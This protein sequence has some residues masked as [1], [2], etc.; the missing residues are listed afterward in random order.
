MGETRS[1]MRGVA[2]ATATGVGCAVAYPDVSIAP[3]A[4]LAYAP[5]MLW[6]TVDRPTPGRAFWVGLLA[7]TILYSVGHN[8]LTFTLQNMSGT[9]APLAWLVLLI[10]AAAMGLHQACW[11]AACV[12][13]QDAFAPDKP[14]GLRWALTVAT[15]L[16][17]MEYVI[18]HQFPWFLGNALYTLPLLMQAADLAGIW[19]IS[20]L[21]ALTSA[22]LVIAA[23]G[24][25]M[26]DRARAVV[27]VVVMLC[28][29][30]GYGQWRIEQ[31]SAVA[32]DRTVTAALIQPNPSLAEKMSGKAAR[33]LPMLDRAEKLTRD[34]LDDPHHG[35][36]IDVVIWPEGSLPFFYVHNEIAPLA[37]HT[38]RPRAPKVVKHT[39]ARAHQFAAQLGKPLLLGSLRKTDAQWHQRTRNSAIL[40][41]GA[42]PRAI[43][44]KRK[45]VPFGEHIPASSLLPS[46]AT[47]I[48]GASN[49]A[50][51]QNSSLMN[52]AGTT[53]AV[54]ICYEA[55]FAGFMLAHNATAEV[56]VNLT[57]DIWFGPQ[58]AP[59]QHLMVQYPRAIELRRPLLRATATG[60]SAH[61][62]AAGRVRS[63]TGTGKT[64]TLLEKVEVRSID[65]VFR[66]LGLW[67]MRLLCILC[68]LLLAVAFHRRARPG[69]T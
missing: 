43:Y 51:G 27:A 38:V 22:L 28:C 52:I 13:C 18:P 65:S 50:P 39:T 37:D 62:D 5:M 16:A 68:V 1:V 36:D 35:S 3:L 66:H 63:R 67:P 21:C 24:P 47:A 29:W 4:L 10:Y 45:L 20:L 9:P 31:I 40:L 49:L 56:I 33:R 6:L 60:I 64:A 44:D 57:D 32:V 58:N 17:V 59:E 15:L 8:W 42:M 14:A 34:A 23:V 69:R 7:G 41:D 25:T 46:L 12:L 54:T 61:I 55:L 2:A 26:R 48:P 30:L 11:A 53:F 19:L